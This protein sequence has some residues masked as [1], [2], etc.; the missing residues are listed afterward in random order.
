M[1]VEEGLLSSRR[2]C[3]FETSSGAIGRLQRRIRHGRKKQRGTEHSLHQVFEV[4]FGQDL[5]GDLE[6]FLQQRILQVAPHLLRPPPSRDRAARHTRPRIRPRHPDRLRR[7]Q[8]Y[9]RVHDRSPL[10]RSRPQPSSSRPHRVLFVA[11]TVM[12]ARA[13]ESSS[14]AR[15]GAAG[16]SSRR[17][18]EQPERR[19]EPVDPRTH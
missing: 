10:R 18:V 3:R 14:F 11:V 19:C 4:I 8:R 17:V 16:K 13:A 12:A 7:V 15:G 1:D 6:P 9:G 2:R 5:V